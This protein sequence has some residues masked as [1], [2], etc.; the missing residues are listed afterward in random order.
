MDAL[1]SNTYTS[2]NIYIEY[3]S[4]FYN[5]DASIIY[6]YGLVKPYQIWSLL[7]K[8]PKPLEDVRQ[9]KRSQSDK[10]VEYNEEPTEISQWLKK[11]KDTFNTVFYWKQVSHLK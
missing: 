7:N 5:Y 11:R 4:L 1:I 8:K 6:K 10:V 3:I 9:Y 2:E